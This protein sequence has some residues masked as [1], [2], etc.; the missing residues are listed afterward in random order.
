[1]IYGGLGGAI[2]KSRFVK[3]VLNIP[4]FLFLQNIKGF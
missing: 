1:M 4:I 3:I 2:I